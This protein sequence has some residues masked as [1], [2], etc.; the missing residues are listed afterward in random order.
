[1][2]ENGTT[3][4]RANVVKGD[5]DIAS[6]LRKRF[7]EALAPV[8]ELIT[9]AEQSGFEVGFGFGKNVFQQTV[10]HQINLMKKY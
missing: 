2:I 7:F 1:M 9:E 10:V 5:K 4:I 8:A 3:P 6:D